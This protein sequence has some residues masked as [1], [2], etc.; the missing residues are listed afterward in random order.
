M[1]T[2]QGGVISPILAN[3]Y[4][5]ELDLRWHRQGGAR[6][7]YGARLVRYADDFLVLASQID[8]PVQGFLTE[9]LEGK[10]GL[11]LNQS[12][13]RILDLREPGSS[14]DFLGYTFRFDRDLKGR[15]KKYLNFFP[16]RKSLERRRAEIK[17]LTIRQRQAPLSHV[18]AEVNKSLLSWGRY[19]AD[20]YPAAS[21]RQ[22]DFYVQVRFDRFLRN[23]SQRRMKVPEGSTL[24]GWLGS[25]G[26]VRLGSSETIA[27]LRGLR[28]PP[29]YRRAG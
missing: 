21:F 12:K 1:G 27:Y 16:S 9:L 23:R 11:R 7:R 10:M 5:H 17:A 4:L 6:D 26:L 28:P 13:T 18:V 14:L 22:M 20:G 3:V 8:E 19:F 25:L 24:P 29:N 15:S 2:P